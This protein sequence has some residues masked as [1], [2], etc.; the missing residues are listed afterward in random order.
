MAHE[1][2]Q[3]DTYRAHAF[4]APAEGRGIGQ[5]AALIH[6]DQ[7]RGEHRT[8]RAGIDPAVSVAAHRMIDRAVVHTR[9]AADTAQ[10]VLKFRAKHIGAAI[11]EQNN[12][13][14]LRPVDIA[15]AARAGGEGG[16]DSD[17]LSRGRARQYTHD[18]RG[19]LQSGHQFFYRCNNNMHPGQN[20]RQVAIALIGDNDGSAGFSNEKIRAGNANVRGKKFIAQN[21]AC[22]GEK[23]HRLAEVARRI[24]M[25]MDTAKIR[26]HLTCIEMD[27]GR[28]DMAGGFAAQLDNIFAKVGFHRRHARALNRGIEVDLLRDHAFALRHGFGPAPLADF[29]H[30]GIGL[31]RSAGKMDMAAA[32]LHLGLIGLD[33][34]VEMGKSVV[35]N[36]AR[37][38]TQGFKFRQARGGLG[39]FVDKA[40]AHILQGFL[41]LIIAQSLMGIGFKLGGCGN[42]CHGF[43]SIGLFYCPDH[44]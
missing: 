10:H 13:I 32:G 19:I 20:L 16:I 12:V 5:V 37:G 7:R 41:Q 34:K 4:A 3:W 21:G 44:R 23:L 36:V 27:G 33:I 8:H 26:F 17:F 22:F 25:G 40:G 2:G 11:V 24:Q 1:L 35:F 43:R 39:A 29:Q 14:F 15:G 38:I 9:A 30:G 6:A 31:R 28:D 42:M 18:L